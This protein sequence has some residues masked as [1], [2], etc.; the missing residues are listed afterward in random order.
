MHLGLHGIREFVEALERHDVAP[1]VQ[2]PEKIIIM[3]PFFTHE[4]GSALL[5]S[6]IRKGVK[7][8][9]MLESGPWLDGLRS[10]NQSL[11]TDLKRAGG[12]FEARRCDHIHAKVFW[13]KKY[14][15]S[16]D[17]WIGSANFTNRADGT[18]NRRNYRCNVEI[19]S[20]VQLNQ[21]V[22]DE[23]TRIWNSGVTL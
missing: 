15:R 23:M 3:S 13:I 6:L 14:D 10:I 1:E 16:I 21:Q 12:D 11:I 18:L 19:I 7:V 20:Q 4:D 17:S 2:L 22:R 8:R 5:I 9:V